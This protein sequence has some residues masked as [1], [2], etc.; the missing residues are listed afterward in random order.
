MEYMEPKLVDLDEGLFVQGACMTGTGATG[1]C[2]PS[3]TAPGL[4]VCRSGMGASRVCR[5]GTG[6]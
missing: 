4:P 2:V 3:G 6:R 1:P 5:T